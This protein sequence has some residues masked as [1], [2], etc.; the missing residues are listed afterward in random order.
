VGSSES[1]GLVSLEREGCDRRPSIVRF[2]MGDRWR[3]V[4]Q[5]IVGSDQA[6]SSRK[7]VPTRFVA[8]R[9]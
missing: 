6:L 1:F 9:S 7:L 5:K 8:W 4:R 3:S 2:D